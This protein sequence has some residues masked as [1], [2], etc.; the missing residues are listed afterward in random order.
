M[1]RVKSP[2]EKKTLSLKKDRRNV[3]GE[4]PTSSRKNIRRG[5]QRSYM[6]LRPTAAQALAS[7]NN[8]GDADEADSLTKVKIVVARRNSFKKDPDV[9]LEDA[10]ERKAKWR[11]WRDRKGDKSK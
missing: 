2:Q 11:S 3:Y 10:I 7:F 4:C 8:T 9:P 6:L 5:K 1:S